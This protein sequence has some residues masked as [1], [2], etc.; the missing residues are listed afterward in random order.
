MLERWL[1][2]E[3]S[4]YVT[5]SAV[6]TSISPNPCLKHS[7]RHGKVTAKWVQISTNC[8]KQMPCN[9]R[10]SDDRSF[11]TFADLVATFVRSWSCSCLK[12]FRFPVQPMTQLPSLRVQAT[13][14][15]ISQQFSVVYCQYLDDTPY[16]D[17]VHWYIMMTLDPGGPQ[18]VLSR[19]CKE[20]SLP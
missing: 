7:T 16:I 2:T 1:E 6:M 18:L 12:Y 17:H 5:C 9:W 8:L 3:L 10:N 11:A 14:T 19:A 13:E 4:C 20:L 15:Y